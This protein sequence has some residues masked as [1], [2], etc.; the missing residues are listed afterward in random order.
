MNN[1]ANN[2]NAVAK[3]LAVALVLTV[4]GVLMLA[5]RLTSSNAALQQRILENGVRQHVPIKI[6]IKKEKEESFKDLKNEKWVREFEL[7]VTNT[8]E[9]PIYYLYLDLVTDVKVGGRPLVFS[10]QYGRAELGDLV[11]K[12]LTDDVP[13]KPKETYIFKLHQGQIPAWEKSVGEGRHADATK[14]HVALQ[15]LSFGDGTGY[16]GNTPYPPASQTQPDYGIKQE[17]QSRSKNKTL[18]RSTSPPS[19]K[20]QKSLSIQKPAKFLPVNFL[21][22]ESSNSLTSV[23][24][25]S[26]QFPEC[27]SVIPGQPQYVCY[28]C[29]FQNRPSLSSSGVCKELVYGSRECTAGTVTYLCQTITIFDCGFGPAPTPSPSPSPS[30]QPCTYCSDPNAL[31]PADCSDPAHPKCDPFLEYQQFGC[32]YRTTCESAGIVPPPPEPCPSGYFRSSNELQPFPLC[33]YL[34][35]VALPPG[36]VSDPDTCQSLSYYWNYTSSTCSSICPPAPCPACF[37]PQNACGRCPSGYV[38]DIGSCCCVFIGSPILVDTLGNGFSLTNGASG[39]EFDLDGNGVAEHLSWTSAGSDD[40]WLALDRNR[41][42]TIDNGTELFGNFTPQPEPP[43]GA[44]KNGFLALAEYD[45]PGKGG[46]GDGIITPK[47]QIFASLR[48]WQDRNHNGKSEAAELFRLQTIGLTTIE[49]EHKLSKRIDEYGNQFRY[50]AKVKDERDAQLGRWA[51]D[52]FL[53]AR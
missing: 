18:E 21:F 35:C 28:N 47:D 22:S 26:C 46:N 10:L 14:L 48:M 50:R 52:V 15:G 6:K 17:R 51:W 20:D 5:S 27:V 31:R 7:E 29:P 4:V 19:I 44:E 2:P 23:P 34:P 33:T 30:P 36:A 39:V 24:D 42:G 53:V 37:Q 40:A 12:A 43:A 8:G 49:L 38:A 16:F 1:S 13:I 32:C 25:G 11:S 45:K 41:N 9:K 3:T